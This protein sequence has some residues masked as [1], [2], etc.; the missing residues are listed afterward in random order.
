MPKGQETGLTKDRASQLQ[1][2][3]TQDQAAT[4]PPFAM[5]YGYIHCPIKVPF[6]HI[7]MK[8]ICNC[9][10]VLREEL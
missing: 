2:G 9:V 3:L 5:V 4:H 10:F 6:I 1:F 7:E 8:F